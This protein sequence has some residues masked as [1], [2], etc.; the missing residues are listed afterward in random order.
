[1]KNQFE[2]FRKKAFSTENKLYDSY[3]LYV[4]WYKRMIRRKHVG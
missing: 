3:Y 2:R 4:F 1:M